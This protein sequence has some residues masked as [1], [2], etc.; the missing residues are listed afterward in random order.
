MVD[1]PVFCLSIL[2]YTMR[3]LFLYSHCSDREIYI[4]VCCS[5]LVRVFNVIDEG[6]IWREYGQVHLRIFDP[7]RSALRCLPVWGVVSGNVGGLSL[8]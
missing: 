4:H 3:D 2:V 6:S 7:R 1:S 8:F 5:S